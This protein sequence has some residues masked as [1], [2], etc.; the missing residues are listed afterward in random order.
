MDLCP[1]P[2]VGGAQCPRRAADEVSKRWDSWSCHCGQG[3]GAQFASCCS[4]CRPADFWDESKESFEG[5]LGTEAIDIGGP[6]A[7]R[8]L[9]YS[10][11]PCSSPVAFLR[12]ATRSVCELP[13]RHL[14]GRLARWYPAE[15]TTLQ[16][17]SAQY[18]RLF[19]I[20]HLNETN[21]LSI[22]D[23]RLSPVKMTCLISFVSGL[24]W[25][26]DRGLGAAKQLG[27]MLGK[28]AR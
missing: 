21:C 23:E 9:D 26:G 1:A 13:S 2:L 17:K 15:V 19:P 22:F 16:F 11:S 28:E 14:V 5:Y 24:S 10:G 25:F 20:S 12:I 4:S 6:T 27:T 7:S 3:A 8:G 18:R